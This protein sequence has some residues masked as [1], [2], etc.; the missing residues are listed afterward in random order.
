MCVLSKSA[1]C[2][3]VPLTYFGWCWKICVACCSSGTICGDNRFTV[4]QGFT[5][6]HTHKWF[7]AKNSKG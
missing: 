6:T 5:N 1:L 7:K 4:G 2:V 3:W